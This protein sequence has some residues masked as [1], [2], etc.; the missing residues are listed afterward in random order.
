VSEVLNPLWQ[1]GTKICTI[2]LVANIAPFNVLEA[3][4]LG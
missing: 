1:V 4:K 2:N 3:A